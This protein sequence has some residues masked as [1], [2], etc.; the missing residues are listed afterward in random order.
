MKKESIEQQSSDLS[1]QNDIEERVQYVHRVGIEIRN[2]NDDKKDWS[3]AE[4]Y[5]VG[6]LNKTGEL[7]AKKDLRD[8]I[9]NWVVHN[10]AESYSCIGY[11]ITDMVY[12]HLVTERGLS[13]E[14]ML[15]TRFNWMAAK[16]LDSSTLRATSFIEKEGSTLKA[17]LDI[18][19]KYGAV[20]D[21]ILPMKHQDLDENNSCMYSGTA[22]EFYA[23]ASNYKITNYFNLIAIEKYKRDYQVKIWKAWI[24]E[25]GPVLVRVKVDQNWID[26]DTGILLK[27][28]S[29]SEQGNHAVIIV[30]YDGDNFI[31]R[32][33]WGDEWGEEGYALV[34]KEYAMVAFDEAYG[35]TIH[36][37]LVGVTKPTYKPRDFWEIIASLFD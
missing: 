9:G 5:R 2:S 27:F 29:E 4:A 1:V 25:Q 20:P 14:H 23:L 26:Y 12:W 32:N 36:N 7:P 19:R 11:A 15:S 35:I 30:G 24:A 37:Q 22:K 33:S 16:E 3:V 34:S 10:Q 28:D 8:S 17:G 18:S 21:D 31:V 13:E 6:Y